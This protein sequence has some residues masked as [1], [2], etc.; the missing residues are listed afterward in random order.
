M[1][2]VRRDFLRRLCDFIPLACMTLP[3]PVILNLR[4]AP[5]FVFI[6]GMATLNLPKSS[7]EDSTDYAVLPLAI[8]NNISFYEYPQPIMW[9]RG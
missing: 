8:V 9:D 1:R 5:L 2:F 6:F 3:V 4:A 7:H